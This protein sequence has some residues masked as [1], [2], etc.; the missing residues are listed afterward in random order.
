VAE[1]RN[2]EIITVLVNLIRES[3]IVKSNAMKDYWGSNGYMYLYSSSTSTSD[4]WL[5]DP[6][7]CH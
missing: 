4:D 6:R 5:Y 3:R 1:I 7:P 2:F